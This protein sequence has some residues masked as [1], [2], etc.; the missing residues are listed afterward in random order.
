MRI[1]YSILF[2]FLYLGLHAQNGDFKIALLKY[3]GGGDWYAN[4]T[5]LPNLIK[6]C[7][8][9]LQMDIEKEPATVEVGSPEIFKYPFVHMTGHGNVIFNTQE[10][11][12]LRK[13]LFSG[14]FLHIDDNYGMD[15]FIRKQL[16]KTFPELKL[17]ELPDNFPIFNSYYHFPKGLPKIHKHD[18]KPSQAFGLFYQGRLILLY[19]Y[20]CDLGD[21]WEDYEVHKDPPE[22]HLEALKM[23]ANILSYI[24][25]Q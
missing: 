5:S 2:L 14:G 12:N 20:E 16:K 18:G 13:Y 25:M 1:K 22:K 17:T 24:F 23:G 8:K 21:G 3:K 4:P 19:T 9:E 6:Y 11:E 7:N 10:S 15:K